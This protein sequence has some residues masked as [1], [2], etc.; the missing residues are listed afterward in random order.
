MNNKAYKDKKTYPSGEYAETAIAEVPSAAEAAHNTEDFEADGAKK[1]K[2]KK[3]D[4]TRPIYEKIIFWFIEI[5]FILSLAFIIVKVII[6]PSGVS[7]ET[8]LDK[9]KSDYVLMLVQMIAGLIVINLP[10]FIERR[11]KVEV[12]SLMTILYLVFLYCAV[13]LGEVK[14]FYYHIPYWDMILHFASALM[15]GCL[16]FTLISLLTRQKLNKLNPW[17]VAAFSLCFTVTIGVVWEFYE[18]SLDGLLSLNMQ[19]YADEAGKF[20]I[21]RYALI[22]TM[23]DLLIDFAGAAVTSVFGLLCL[24][25]TPK[26]LDR[27]IIEPIKKVSAP[28]SSDSSEKEKTLAE[29]EKTAR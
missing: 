8:Q 25:Y 23:D 17:L 4:D 24:K 11:L 9:N 22:D 21:G 7:D 13:Y 27:L 29:S 19:K 6:T 15:L 3:F 28:T 2:R 1:K 26:T 18:Y 16:S 20:F 14:S 10:S 5:T 12:P